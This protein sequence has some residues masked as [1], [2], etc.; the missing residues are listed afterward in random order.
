M[1]VIKV[2]NLFKV[3]GH[4]PKRVFPLLEKGLTKN[5]ILEKTGCG[6]GINN[7]SFEIHKKEI[8]VLMGLSGSGK[9]TVIRCLNRLIEPTCGEVLID[10][11][12]IMK[13]DKEELLQ[14]RRSKLSMVFQHFGLLPHRSVI[15]NVVYGLEVAGTPPENALERAV[16]ALELVGLKG[17]EDSM[18]RELS[19]GMQQRVGLAR[20]LASDPEVLLM[21]EAF[22]ALDPLIRTDMQDELLELQARMHKT[23]VFITH[24]LDEAL[25]LGDRIG[26]MKDGEIVQ[27]G[28]PEDILTKPANDYVKRFVKNVDRSKVIT[29]SSLMRKVRTI[30]V[31][32]DGAHVALRAMEKGKISSI[33]VVNSDRQ[34]QGLL[35]V[36]DAVKLE[37]AG[38]QDVSDALQT[39]LYVASPDTPIADLLHTAMNARYPITIQD[40]KGCLLGV[41]DRST[42]LAEMYEKDKDEPAVTPLDEVLAEAV[43]EKGGNA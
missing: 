11:Q 7:A 42:I 21:D 37:R 3:F 33:F 39:D 6:V 28:T 1:G 24:D 29:A 9:S 32:K 43:E 13:M 18:P 10:G 34:L 15:R 4:D 17:Y 38:K 14:V 35:R 20:A 23:I 12:D 19:G 26:I 31:P 25:K 22:S 8:F 16:D 5:E 2:N 36:D 30:T 41:L 27:I 40:D